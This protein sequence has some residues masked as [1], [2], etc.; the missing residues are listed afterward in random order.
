[1]L[2][3]LILFKIKLNLLVVRMFGICCDGVLGWAGFVVCLFG[4]LLVVGF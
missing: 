1:M 4:V 2:F 3:Y